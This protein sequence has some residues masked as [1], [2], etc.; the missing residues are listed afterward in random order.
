M[1]TGEKIVGDLLV[2]RA[3]V[4]EIKIAHQNDPLWDDIQNRLDEI[5]SLVKRDMLI[6]GY[7]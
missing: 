7:K 3:D 1:I 5:I 6:F 2:T 4:Q